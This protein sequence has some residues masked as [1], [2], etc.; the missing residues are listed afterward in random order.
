MKIEVWKENYVVYLLDW[1]E[2]IGEIDVYCLLV[3]FV[4][5]YFGYVF[6]EIVFKLFCVEVE[7]L[8]YLLMN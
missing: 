4:Y 1:F 2:V 5:N 6:F 3:C 8:G 7:V